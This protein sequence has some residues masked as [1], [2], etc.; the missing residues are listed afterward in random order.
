LVEEEG[1][2]LDIEAYK[3]IGF[4]QDNYEEITGEDRSQIYAEQEFDYTII[5][6]AK[7]CGI[8]YDWLC[9]EW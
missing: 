8:S 9:E 2:V 7:A 3:I 5:M 6:I 4:I 1:Q